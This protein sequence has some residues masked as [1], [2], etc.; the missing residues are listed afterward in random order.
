MSNTSMHA[1][2]LER[3]GENNEGKREGEVKDES[4]VVR[5]VHARGELQDHVKARKMPYANEMLCTRGS[6]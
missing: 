5:W 3:D 6:I 2:Q 4:R 1:M